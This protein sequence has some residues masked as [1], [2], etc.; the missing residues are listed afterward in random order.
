[1]FKLFLLKDTCM[2]MDLIKKIEIN[3]GILFSNIQRIICWLP[4]LW[5]DRD[6]DYIYLYQ[7]IEYKLKRM[8]NCIKNGYSVYPEKVTKRIKVCREL[9]NRLAKN[10]YTNEFLSE[11]YDKYPLFIENVKGKLILKECEKNPLDEKKYKWAKQDEEYR[12]RYDID[13][14]FYLL[15]KYHRYWWD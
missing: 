6:W 12:Q 8:E 15:K 5:K 3:I 9:L 11:Y 1:M 4:K 13:Y 7:I 14:L 10:D 2:I